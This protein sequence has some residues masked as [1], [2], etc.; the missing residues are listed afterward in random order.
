MDRVIY[1][2][3]LCLLTMICIIQTNFGRGVLRV[4]DANG[5]FDEAVVYVLEYNIICIVYNSKI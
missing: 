2:F 5:Y 3:H 1:V 4:V